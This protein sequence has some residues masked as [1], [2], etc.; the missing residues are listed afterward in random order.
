[1][2][3]FRCWCPD[4]GDEDDAAKVDASDAQSAAESYAEENYSDMDFPDEIEVSVKDADGRVTRWTVDA[5]PSVT[6]SAVCI[7]EDD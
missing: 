2:P 7:E 5:E 4:D 6:F 3:M 1:M